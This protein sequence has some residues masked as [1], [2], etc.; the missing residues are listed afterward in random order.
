MA[1]P[2]RHVFT[3]ERIADRWRVD[4][5]RVVELVHTK[6]LPRAFLVTGPARLAL[7]SPSGEM[8]YN[9]DTRVE[10]A[11]AKLLVATASGAP[12]FFCWQLAQVRRIYEFDAKFHSGRL[13]LL[14]YQ[15]HDRLRGLGWELHFDP[16]RTTVDG[17]DTTL[18]EVRDVIEHERLW[19]IGP[20][21]Q[22]QQRDSRR[23]R[24]TRK[25]RCRVVA[26]IIWRNDPQTTL[27]RVFRHAWIQEVACEGKPPTEKTFREWVKDLN[28]DR[29][30]GRRPI[31]HKHTEPQG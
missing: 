23:L 4:V 19:N 2:G 14:Q 12:S 31:E 24:D 9:S 13:S 22:R 16:S 3:L 25:Q 17:G 28:P 30:P 11:S 5:A 18:L 29:R 10:A 7:R 27:A 6:R 8:I 26:E 15:E 21:S 20:A 1:L